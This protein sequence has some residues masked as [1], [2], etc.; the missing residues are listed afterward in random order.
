L[1]Q[2]RFEREGA[3]ANV[4]FPDLERCNV[5]PPAIVFPAMVDGRKVYC[6]ISAAALMSR[7]RAAN[8]TEQSLLHA[9]R[10]NRSAI[11]AAAQRKIK[12]GA[13]QVDGAIELGTS[14]F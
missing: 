8:E 14:D 5:D 6:R 4:Y 1:W 12:Q 9:F 13:L 7:F 11:R 2:A 10:A 3:V